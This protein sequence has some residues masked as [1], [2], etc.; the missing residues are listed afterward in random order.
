MNKGLIFGIIGVLLLGGAGTLLLTQEQADA[1]SICTT[2][3]VI[4]TF[5]RLSSTNKTGY[6]T[7]NS[8]TK[9][10]VCTK[11]EWIPVNDYLKSNNLTLN[12]IAIQPLTDSQ[13]D[14]NGYPI[15]LNHVI[16]SV[17][18]GKINIDGAL[19][20]CPACQY[21]LKCICADNSTCNVKKCL[22]QQ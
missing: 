9:Q 15:V 18:D 14:E 10:A 19:Y 11:G 20:D 4:A 1:S 22:E 8:T 17:K 13:I 5:E 6:W 16:T 3:L 21:K 7:V 12:D 2:S